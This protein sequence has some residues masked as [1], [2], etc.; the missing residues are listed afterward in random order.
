MIIRASDFP[1]YY[2]SDDEVAEDILAA[3][4]DALSAIERCG[5]IA[6]YNFSDSF[7]SAP[8]RASASSTVVWRK[9]QRKKSASFRAFERED[10]RQR[11][12]IERPE[13][14]RQAPVPR[15]PTRREEIF[16]SFCAKRWVNFPM[17]QSV[18]AWM[19]GDMRSAVKWA[20]G[21][22]IAN[23]FTRDLSDEDVARELLELCNSMES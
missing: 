1:D 8:A 15:Q 5:T 14:P 6:S 4:H 13:P 21:T 12:P 7:Y 10:A 11:D 20:R 16:H 22:L 17:R 19:V 3:E 9:R 23:L 18:G 2:L